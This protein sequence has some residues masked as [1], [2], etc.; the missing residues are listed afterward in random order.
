MQGAWHILGIDPT[1]DERA[2][3]RAY[4]KQLKQTRPEDDAEG[5]QAL[6][7]AY[8]QALAEVRYRSYEDDDGEAPE[9]T[10]EAVDVP[11]PE[12][13][14]SP[15]Q[16]APDEVEL[17]RE[18]MLRNAW[19]EAQQLW[20]AFLQAPGDAPAKH[21]G[22]LMS[23][24][25]L[26]LLGNDAL[27]VMAGRYCASDGYDPVVR[28][29]AVQHFRWEEDSSHLSRIDGATA[30][31]AMARYRADHGYQEL[32]NDPY[33][34]EAM[35]A[36]IK[37]A[38]PKFALST[39]NSHAMKRMATLLQVL[40]WRHPEVI[41][42][43][44]QRE[45]VEWWQEKV[46]SKKYYIQTALYSV[47]AGLL[48]TVLL[49]ASGI[50]STSSDQTIFAMLALCLATGLAGG[51]LL[52]FRPPQTLIDAWR[53][54]KGE[55]V[56]AF[57]HSEATYWRSRYGWLLPF[58]AA[59]LAMFYPEPSLLLQLVVGTAMLASAGLA[60]LSVSPHLNQQGWAWLAAI[61][62]VLW[63]FVS[64]FI[65]PGWHWSISLMACACLQCL[66]NTGEFRSH[67]LERLSGNR[68]MTARA[69]WIAGVIALVVLVNGSPGAVMLQIP[70]AW[71]MLIAGFVLAEFTVSLFII[72]PA[73]FIGRAVING[74][75]MFKD[76]TD[77]RMVTL[78][79]FLLILTIF[80]IASL[81]RAG[82]ARTATNNY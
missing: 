31:Y 44:L 37:P 55:K 76:V 45:M 23:A 40:Q 69:V 21:L 50:F 16:P 19:E 81:Y 78:A 11:A 6:R 9:T 2:I 20:Q 13:A 67:D 32:R 82:S 29:A 51:A 72:W 42:Y 66:V 26:S 22:Q 27:E 15:V 1:S 35:E 79:D 68:L 34:A 56:D 64:Q 74:Q 59:S 65:F 71:L 60:L 49:G 8:D 17:A 14:A 4:A 41:T 61:S 36:L 5:F 75:H 70:F 33:L 43:H 77:G 3:K 47:G 39:I 48:L 80:M 38:P 62:C 25:A 30:F 58:T 57:L 53:E 10:Q 46:D 12:A 54:W 73:F 52:A 7:S 18:E 24:A 28:D 63:F